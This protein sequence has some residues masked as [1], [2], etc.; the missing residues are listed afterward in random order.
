MVWSEALMRRL[1]SR[2]EG[3]SSWA[4][5]AMIFIEGAVDDARLMSLLREAQRARAVRRSRGVASS[6]RMMVE[7]GFAIEMSLAIWSL[8]C[9]PVERA[10]SGSAQSFGSARPVE[11]RMARVWL[12]GW[13]KRLTM[14]W[15]WLIGGR[16]VG[17]MVIGSFCWR[18]F[19]SVDFP[20]PEGPVMSVRGEAWILLRSLD[21]S[22]H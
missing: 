8:A 1:V 13:L 15:D 16:S 21:E 10:R 4:A 18:V 22:L 7:F 11:L 14:G 2:K 3:R 17:V 6:S 20:D 12:S 19:K 5:A 9:S